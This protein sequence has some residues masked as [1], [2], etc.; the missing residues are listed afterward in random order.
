MVTVTQCLPNLKSSPYINAMLS[1]PDYIASYERIVSHYL[2][3]KE[4]YSDY[5]GALH[6]NFGY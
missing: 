1:V 6:N 4:A 3:N 5:A 2:Q